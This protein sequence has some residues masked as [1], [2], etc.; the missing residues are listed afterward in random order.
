MISVY[1][2]FDCQQ[3]HEVVR[4]TANTLGAELP[5]RRTRDGRSD[6]TYVYA[7]DDNPQLFEALEQIWT[8]YEPTQIGIDRAHTS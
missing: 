3:E 4:K 1:I 5:K 6:V 8:F 2:K 7:V